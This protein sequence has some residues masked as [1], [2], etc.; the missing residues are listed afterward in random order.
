MR[1][2]KCDAARPCLVPRTE[3]RG[4]E[5]AVSMKTK[6]ISY[7]HNALPILIIRAGLTPGLVQSPNRARPLASF[8]VPTGHLMSCGY[9]RFSCSNKYGYSALQSIVQVN[10]EIDT[11]STSKQS[12]LTNP[13]PKSGVQCATRM[14]AAQICT[15]CHIQACNK[16]IIL[17]WRM[18][19]NGLGLCAV[20]ERVGDEGIGFFLKF[21]KSTGQKHG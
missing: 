20:V 3:V 1:L 21:D 8:R 9:A 13:A 14:Y 4:A 10:K 7:H 6:I 17:Q 12:Q 15:A 16:G 19:E 5:C 2:V 11:F 18:Q